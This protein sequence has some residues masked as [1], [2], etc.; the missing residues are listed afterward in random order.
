[1]CLERADKSVM[2]APGDDD[3]PGLEPL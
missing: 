1:M 2:E 3:V